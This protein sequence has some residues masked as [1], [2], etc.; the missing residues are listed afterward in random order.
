MLDNNIYLLDPLEARMPVFHT[1]VSSA[2]SMRKVNTAE[3]LSKK[4]NILVKILVGW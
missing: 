2:A 1:T 3:L 4:K